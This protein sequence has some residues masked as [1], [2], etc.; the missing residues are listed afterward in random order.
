MQAAGPKTGIRFNGIMKRIGTI[1]GVVISRRK[2]RVAL[3]KITVDNQIRLNWNHQ[4]SRRDKHDY[5]SLH[6]N[7]SSHP[8]FILTRH[9]RGRYEFTLASLERNALAPHCELFY[10][11]NPQKINEI[12]ANFE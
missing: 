9:G 7:I 6:H 2:T 5:T 1:H 10:K 3:F 4:Q 12:L 8:K 11:C